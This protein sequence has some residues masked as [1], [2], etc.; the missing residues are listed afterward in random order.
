MET[1]D[2]LRPEYDLHSLRVRKLGSGRKSFGE[3]T[4]RLDPDVAEV[5]PNSESVN[6]ALRFLIRIAK[7]NKAS[8]SI[9]PD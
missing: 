9:S 4:I 7:E 5:F 2:E 3:T 1:E 8:Q 6:E